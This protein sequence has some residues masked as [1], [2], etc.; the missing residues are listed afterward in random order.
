[1]STRG[2]LIS[3][4]PGVK[5][6]AWATWVSGRLTNAGA[7]I[8]ADDFQR[9]AV[10]DT[11]VVEKPQV[12]QTRSAK[13]PASDLIDLAISVGRI[14]VTHPHDQLLTPLPREWKGQIPKAVHHTRIAMAL[15]EA[16]KK[17]VLDACDKNK[18]RTKD[19]MDA[20]G[21]GLWALGRT[22]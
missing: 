15:T 4:D 14:I 19:I 5:Y 10:V 12:Y 9:C 11:L 1:M 20:V 7:D 17:I 6:Y 18:S 13:G 21:L 8:L 3:I 22:V 2:I 16:E